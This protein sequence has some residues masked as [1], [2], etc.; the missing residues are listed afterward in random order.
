MFGIIIQNNG[1]RFY[2]KILVIVLAMLLIV[3]NG[4]SK[5]KKSNI[6]ESDT[7]SE[8]NANI[9]YTSLP[10]DTD[11][12]KLAIINERIKFPVG[13]PM[14]ELIENFKNTPEALYATALY[15]KEEFA[16][17]IHENKLESYVEPEILG[18]EDSKIFDEVISEMVSEGQENEFYSENS[19]PDDNEGNKPKWFLQNKYHSNLIMSYSKNYHGEFSCQDIYVTAYQTENRDVYRVF[20]GCEIG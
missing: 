19:P 15:T 4:C 18:Y 5:G 1:Y 17:L 2:K 13:F 7:V 6:L 10:N 14:P 16:Q 8:S 11:E 9:L 12:E 3:L 20:F